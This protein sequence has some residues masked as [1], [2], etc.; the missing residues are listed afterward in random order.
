MINIWFLLFLS[1]VCGVPMFFIG[2]KILLDAA[3]DDI[4]YPLASC[5]TSMY[6]ECMEEKKH[7]K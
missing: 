7:V 5:D 4:N 6:E 3:Q 1:V 2:R